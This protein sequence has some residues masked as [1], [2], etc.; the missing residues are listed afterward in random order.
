M[1]ARE[2]LRGSGE[3]VKGSKKRIR[4]GSCEV[5]DIFLRFAD[6]LIWSG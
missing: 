6:G 4:K 2:R 5:E 3:A 1:V